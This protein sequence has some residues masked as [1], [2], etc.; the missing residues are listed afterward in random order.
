LCRTVKRQVVPM[1]EYSEEQLEKKRLACSFAESK[2]SSHPSGFANKSE[3]FRLLWE[4]CSEFGLFMLPVPVGFGGLEEDIAGIAAI[5]EGLGEGSDSVGVLFSV[6]VHIWACILPILHYGSEQQKGRYLGEMMEGIR[7]GAHAISEDNAGSDVWN[8]E[9]T[10]EETEEGYC[11]QGIKNYVTNAPDADVYIVYARQKG[12]KGFKGVSCF[13]VEKGMKGFTAGKPIEK[14]GMELSS[15]S[16]I[17]LNGCIV[18]KPNLLGKPGQG[19]NIFN[20]TME[21][22]RTFLLTF[23]VGMMERQLRRCVGFAKKR[24]QFKKRIIDFQS[25][26]NRLAD[27]KVRLEASRLFMYKVIHEKQQGKN[28]YLSSSIAKLFISESLVQNSMNA[29]EIHGACG[30]IREY[31]IEEALRDSMGSIFY[32]G[33]SDIQRNII[34]GML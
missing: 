3:L 14:M 31:G 1:F 16:S 25:V 2:L 11:L 13:I 29:M 8:L 22:E 20:T 34:A 24:E 9:A 4:R 17:Y 32:S 5:M 7:I 23:Q 33:T 21:Y 26:S 18:P 30:Y 12:T 15:M 27:M 6:N 28:I 10:Y 19:M